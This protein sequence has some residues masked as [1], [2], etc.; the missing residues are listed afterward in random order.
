MVAFS[1]LLEGAA[2]KPVSIFNLA[3]NELNCFKMDIHQPRMTVRYAGVAGT[4]QQQQVR[5]LRSLVAACL[6]V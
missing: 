3:E 2:N 6:C 4:Q 1:K 5:L